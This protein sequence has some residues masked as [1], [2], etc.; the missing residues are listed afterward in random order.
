MERVQR[1]ISDELTHLVGKECESDTERY[2]L[3]AKI[4]REE[5]LT[6]PPHDE[7]TR[8]CAE[9]TTYYKEDVCTRTNEMFVAT[10]VCFCDIPVSDLYIH[11]RKYSRFG[12]A[13]RKSFIAAKG[14]APVYYVPKSGSPSV[15]SSPSA[16]DDRGQVFN[17]G[18]RECYHLLDD[19]ACSGSKWS[20][21]AKG[22]QSFL[23]ANV[24]AFIR[25]F[26]HLLA[27]GDADN[28]YFEREWR[29]LGSLHFGITDVCRILMPE[30][31]ARQFRQD[32]PGYFGELVFI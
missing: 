24:F 10:M 6:Y 29:I 5:W 16:G 2:K 23:S 30:E 22:V 17:R 18:I 3:L 31:Y 19:L 13:F 12:L 4:L 27:D 15:H 8:K 20:Q 28:Y 26:D 32:F 14:G 11:T 9:V 1:Y 25:G 21:R 7:T